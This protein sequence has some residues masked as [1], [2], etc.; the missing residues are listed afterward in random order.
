[1]RHVWSWKLQY[2][3]KKL[4]IKETPYRICSLYGKSQAFDKETAFA[5]TAESY[6]PNWTRKTH[7]KVTANLFQDTVGQSFKFLS[8]T[9][10]FLRYTRWVVQKWMLQCYRICMTVQDISC[11]CHFSNFG[12]LLPVLSAYFR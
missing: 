5:S 3:F 12:N 6:C 2:T 10:K 9:G 1:M 11:F 7:K 8:F 4:G